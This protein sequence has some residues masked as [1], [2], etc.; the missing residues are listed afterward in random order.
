MPSAWKEGSGIF[1]PEPEKQ[2]CR[3]LLSIGEIICNFTTILPDFGHWG[4]MNLDHDFV[5]VSKLSEDQKKGPH[6]KWNTFFHEFKWT[7][8][9]RCTPESNYW[10]NADVYHTQTIGGI[11]SNYWGGYIPPIPP[12]F[13]TP[14]EKESYFETKSFRMITLTSFQ[15]KW[16]GTLI[17]YHINDDKKRAGKA[18][19]IAVRFRAGISTET[20]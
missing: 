7:P 3:S 9:F 12:G 11:Q 16:L 15:L 14:A 2:E 17:L 13:G 4:E 18:F 6:Q 1:L 5:Q 19:C 20:A 8:T 10:E